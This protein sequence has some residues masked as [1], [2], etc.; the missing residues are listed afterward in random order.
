MKWPELAHLLLFPFQH[1]TPIK[2]TALG[3]GGGAW[4]GNYSAAAAACCH[5]V[6]LLKTDPKEPDPRMYRFIV[7]SDLC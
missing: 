5:K 3:V 6:S 7:N 2:E 4:E 1:F